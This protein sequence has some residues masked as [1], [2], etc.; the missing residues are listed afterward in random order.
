MKE[1]IVVKDCVN[2]DRELYKKDTILKEFDKEKDSRLLELGL[3]EEYDESKHKKVIVDFESELKATEEK[4]AKEAEEKENLQAQVEELKA[5]VVETSKLTKDKLPDS[6]AKYQGE[7]D[8]KEAG[9][10]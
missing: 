1:Y 8:G 5:I 2:S 4:L 6:F 9:G 7:K 10:N 3:V